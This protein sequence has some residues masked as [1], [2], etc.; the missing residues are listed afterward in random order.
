MNT[1]Y[2]LAIKA[3]DTCDPKAPLGLY[4]V[5]QD[6]GKTVQP[7]L[8]GDEWQLIKRL[9]VLFAWVRAWKEEPDRKKLAERVHKFLGFGVGEKNVTVKYAGLIRVGDGSTEQKGRWHQPFK[10]HHNNGRSAED[11]NLDVDQAE[12]LTPLESR[13]CLRY[14]DEELGWEDSQEELRKYPRW[15]TASAGDLLD[16]G[17]YP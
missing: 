2:E 15:M 10:R 16:S 9:T 8:T 14:A 3:L 17:R 7:P 5:L 11:F 12:A 1:L 13:L 6:L 4:R